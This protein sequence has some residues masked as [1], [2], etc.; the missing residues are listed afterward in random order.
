VHESRYVEPLAKNIAAMLRF[1]VVVGKRYI[2][3]C[4]DRTE[5]AGNMCLDMKYSHRNIKAYPADEI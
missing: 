5:G 3:F 4:E 2:T 1:E